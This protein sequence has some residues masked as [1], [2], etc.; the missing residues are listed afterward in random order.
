[1]QRPLDGGA[2]GGGE[3][4]RGIVG[5][6]KKPSLG[7][8]HPGIRDATAL[9]QDSKHGAPRGQMGHGRVRPAGREGPG[10]HRGP[11]PPWRAA[12]ENAAAAATLECGLLSPQGN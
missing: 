9:P 8:W 10:A 5:E 12:A 6:G 1:M 3:N 11:S 4:E 2:G 7:A